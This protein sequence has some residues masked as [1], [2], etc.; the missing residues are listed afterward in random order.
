MATPTRTALNSLFSRWSALDRPVPIDEI[1]DGLAGVSL[2]REDFSTDELRFDEG[3]YKRNLVFGNEHF[4][5]LLLCW[6]SGQMTSIH[7]HAGSACL[8]RIV[9]GTATEVTFT[10]SSCG[11]LFPAQTRI[12]APGTEVSSFDQDI[13]LMGNLEGAGKDLIS[14]HIYSPPLSKM[15]LFSLAET[16]MAKHE[17]TRERI[18][19]LQQG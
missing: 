4:S 14:L 6:R 8:V 11:T 2:S 15:K 17:D 18:Q 12:A 5:A 10:W 13:H 1:R 9:E 3:C 16:C 19:R 7:N